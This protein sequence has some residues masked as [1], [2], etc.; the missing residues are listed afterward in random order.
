MNLPFGGAKGGIK[1]SPRNTTAKQLERIT[2]RYT[3]ELIKKNFIGPGIQNGQFQPSAA[4]PGIHTLVYLVDSFINYQLDTS[5]VY[6]PITPP[7]SPTNIVLGDDVL[8]S[9]ITLPF[10]FKCRK[11]PIIRL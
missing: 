2:R 8:S 11:L 3:V 1:I 9:A 4:G 10:A 7:A 6:T 5:C